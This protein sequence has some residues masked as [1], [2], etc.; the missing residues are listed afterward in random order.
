MR[1]HSSL[2]LKAALARVL[3]FIIDALKTARGNRAKA[4]RLRGWP[5]LRVATP[6][7]PA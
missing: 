4:A 7:G 5:R 6:F 1:A 3:E 2:N